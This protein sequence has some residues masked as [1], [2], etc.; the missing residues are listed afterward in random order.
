MQR[1]LAQI[2]GDAHP[3]PTRAH[4]FPLTSQPSVNIHPSFILAPLLQAGDG[5]H[6]LPF[7]FAWTK[8]TNADLVKGIAYSGFAIATVDHEKFVVDYYTVQNGQSVPLRVT[9]YKGQA[10]MVQFAPD[11]LKTVKL[12]NTV[13]AQAVRGPGGRAG[14][15][16]QL[17]LCRRSLDP[18][19]SRP[20]PSPGPLSAADPDEHGP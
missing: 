6:G 12:P 15:W 10:P 1:S 17:L 5:G 16:R 18:R 14:C 2:I 13:R 9:T 4:A 20:L 19:C 8:W 3:D 7:P 11:G